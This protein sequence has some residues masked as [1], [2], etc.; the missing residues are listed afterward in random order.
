MEIDVLAVPD[1]I[2]SK[3]LILFILDLPKSVSGRAMD[4]MIHLSD[5]DQQAQKGLAELNHRQ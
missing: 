5:I 2:G 4:A 1:P 3:A